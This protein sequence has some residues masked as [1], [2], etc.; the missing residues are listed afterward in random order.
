M[1]VFTPRQIRRER[2]HEQWQ[3]GWRRWLR[4]SVSVLLLISLVV[5]GLVFRYEEIGKYLILGY[6]ILAFVLHVRSDTT[7]KMVLI[8]LIC[9]PALSVRGDDELIATLSVYALLLLGV[10]IGSLLIEQVFSGKKYI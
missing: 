3:H 7:F 8:I 6:A 10:G 5:V 4:I 1:R 9:M 2:Q